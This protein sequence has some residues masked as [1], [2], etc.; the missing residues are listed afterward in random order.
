MSEETTNPLEK[1]IN[2]LDEDRQCY[3]EFSEW[4]E[5]APHGL[6]LISEEDSVVLLGIVNKAIENTRLLAKEVD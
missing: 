3:E 2:L 6:G 4:L 5:A 1:I